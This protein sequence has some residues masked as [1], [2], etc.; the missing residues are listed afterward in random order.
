MKKKI[1]LVALFVISI[2][3]NAKIITVNNNGGAQYTS[4]SA[5]I[6]AATTGDTLYISPSANSYG[7]VTVDRKLVIYGGGYDIKSSQLNVGTT[8]D[9]FTIDSLQVNPKLISGLKVIGIQF[10]STF[11]QDATQKGSY[12]YIDRCKFNGYLYIYGPTVLRNSIINSYVDLNNSK[13]VIISNNIFYGNYIG[14]SNQNSVVVSNNVFVNPSNGG[15]YSF[16]SAVIQNNIFYN[17]TGFQSNVNNNSFINN[18]LY[19]P[20]A[21]IAFPPVNNSGSSGNFSNTGTDPLFVNLPTN[22]STTN[23]TN[24]DYRLQAGSP[25]KTFGTDGK[26]LGVYGG[27]SPI[28]NITGV[29]PIPQITQLNVNTLFVPKNG[30]LNVSVKARSEK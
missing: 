14:T 9:Q 17:A 19:N 6:L 1:L 22:A 26:E 15:I 11:S 20:S 16:Q 18:L 4:L 23:Q 5:A 25:V 3:I 29:P 2:G 27:S 21:T 13:N 28:P 10:N 24:Y 30:T 8:I 7:N 12:I